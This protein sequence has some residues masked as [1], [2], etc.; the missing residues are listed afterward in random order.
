M[1]RTREK[2]IN[3]ENRTWEYKWRNEV[4]DVRKEE[5]IKIKLDK[6]IIF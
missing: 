3:I 1:E 6:I 4:K 2:V 5:I